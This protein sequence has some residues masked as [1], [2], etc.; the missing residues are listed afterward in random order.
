VGNQLPSPTLKGTLPKYGGEV[1]G[2]WVSIP[3]EQPDPEYTEATVPVASPTSGACTPTNVTWVIRWKDKAAREAG[4]K[5][6]RGDKLYPEMG[7]ARKRIC[8]AKG[9]DAKSYKQIEVKYCVDLPTM[10]APTANL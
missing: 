4:W 1:V 9:F 2:F 7:A 10:V 5:G 8:A 6:F 3:G